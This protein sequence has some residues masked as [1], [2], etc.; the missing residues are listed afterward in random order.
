[1][2]PPRKYN[3]PRRADFA[4]Y[5]IVYADRII[6]RTPYNAAFVDTIKQVPSKLRSFVKDGRQL[7]SALREHL[8]KNEDYFSSNVELASIVESLVNSVAASKGLSDSWIVALAAPELFEF[9]MAA[10]LQQFPDLNLYDVRILT[11]ETHKD[12]PEEDR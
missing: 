6:F 3:F 7:E 10:A 12:E 8:E 1:M 4:A 5:A 2:G 9:S 11:E